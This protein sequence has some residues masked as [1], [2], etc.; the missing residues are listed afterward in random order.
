MFAY[1]LSNAEQSSEEE[2]AL[3]DI[4]YRNAGGTA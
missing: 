2:D 1:M 3:Q 4:Q